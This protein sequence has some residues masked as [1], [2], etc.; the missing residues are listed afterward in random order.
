MINQMDQTLYR[1]S[2][3][4]AQQQKITY[5]MS[6][7]KELQ[8]GSDNAVLY[9]RV[10]FIDDKIRTF[11]GLENQ[12][13]KAAIQNNAADSS[14]K[15]IKKILDQIKYELIKANTDTT[16]DDGKAAISTTISGLKENLYQLANTQVENQYVF[17]GSDT[18]VKPFEKNA[19][20]GKVTYVGDNQL[21]KIAVEEGSYRE[22]GV[23]G[24]DMMM[25]P[26]SSA[27]KGGTLTFQSTNRIVDQAGN[28][29]KLNSPTN[30]TLIKYDLD[31]NATTET[32]NFVANDGLTP[33]TYSATMPSTDGIKFE[34]KTNI[35]DFIDDTVN[36]LK[37]LSS[38]G[39]PI[40]D[41]ESKTLIS[42]SVE[43]SKKAYDGVNVSHSELGGK[44]KIFEISLE[45]ISSK[46]TQYNILSQQI[47]AADLTKVA[48][49]AKSLE[50]TYTALYST[51]SKTN[52]L[53]LVN[54][55]K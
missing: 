37:K 28:E 47:G 19:T 1:L 5:Q 27:T 15:E 24:F 10:V 8:N 38:A 12:V 46:L 21:R 44:N 3:L 50:L 25:Y 36:A 32:I 30:D 35:F 29:W 6:T 52:E 7:K 51:I 45:R 23:T 31:G 43:E 40:T 48:V 55:L 41:A 54:F 22:A 16:G 14:M 33:P 39:N 2:N 11:E 49:E 20:T 13:E 4:D 17:S 42:K 9:A 34:A 53:S 18:S 26:S